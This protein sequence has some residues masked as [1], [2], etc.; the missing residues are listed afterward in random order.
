MIASSGCCCRRRSD[1]HCI[2]SISDIVIT[3]SVLQ[4]A[5]HGYYRSEGLSFAEFVLRLIEGAEEIFEALGEAEWPTSSG[6]LRVV[7]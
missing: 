5:L 4:Y 3:M 7:V 2:S 1:S 6:W